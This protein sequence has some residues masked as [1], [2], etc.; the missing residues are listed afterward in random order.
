MTCSQCNTW[1]FRDYKYCRQCGTK[2][3]S[4]PATVG[5]GMAPDQEDPQVERLLQQAFNLMDQ[6]NFDE[7]HSAILK[8]FAQAVAGVE[9]FRRRRTLRV[10]AV[11]L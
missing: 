4:Q 1:N 10:D 8:L 6:G 9:I 5:R 2:L 7:A 3:E 11:Q